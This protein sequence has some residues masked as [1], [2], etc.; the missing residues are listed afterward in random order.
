[1]GADPRQLAYTVLSREA[2]GAYSD[3]ALDAELGAHPQLDPRDRALVTELVYGVL[4]YR[5]RLDFALRQSCQKPLEQLDPPVLRLLRLGAYQILCLERIPASAAVN[6]SVEL[7]RRMRLERATGF[8]NGVLRGLLRRLPEIPWPPCA[9]Q[10]VGYLQH[11]LSLPKWLAKTWLDEYGAEEASQLAEAML[12]R[13]PLTIRANTLVAS[14]EELLAELAAAGVSA[15]PCRYAPEGIRLE[16]SRGLG[17]LAPDRFQVQ[18]QASMLVPH[19]LG[20]RPGERVLDACAAPG[21]KTTQLA[22]LAGNRAE[23]IALELHPQRAELV[24]QGVQRLGC[25]GVDVR[26][27]D[28]TRPPAFIPPASLDRV[29]LDAPCSGLGVL[30]RNPETRWRRQPESLAELADLQLQLLDNL[31]SLL[32]PGGSLVYSLCTTTPIETEQVVQRFLDG[33][34]DYRRVDLHELVPSGWHALLDERGALRTSPVRH[35]AMDAFYAVR[36]VRGELS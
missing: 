16:N 19:L 25:S 36:F 31:A 27:W 33:H 29:L 15:E 10:P 18:D 12:Q 32:R 20:I 5:G 21:G 30:R 3:L 2:E 14:R 22:A 28:L 35:D 1:M 9:S 24:R 34:P 17:L 11:W 23:L 13:P 8:I 26:C 6:S 4:R 7:A